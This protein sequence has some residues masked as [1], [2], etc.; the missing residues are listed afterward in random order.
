MKLFAFLSFAFV[1]AAPAFAAP[2]PSP[3]P[4]PAKIDFNRDIRPVLSENCFACHGPDAKQVKGGLRLDQ[5]D[6]TIKQAKS[7]K[8][9]IVPKQPS[10]SEL[11]RRITTKDTD[12]LMPPPE[13]HK[14]LG[15]REVA[16]LQKWIEQ[17]A[18]YQAHW[19]YVPPLKPAVPGSQNGVDFLVQQR[20]KAINLKPSPEADRRTLARRLYFDLIGLPP[21]S[22]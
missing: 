14:K 10:K 17:G 2:A 8:I 18:E 20:L 1:C 7:G 11:V 3:S 22:A 5:R 4:L 13:S 12:D 19:A 6:S 9:A 15:S 16:L 21:T